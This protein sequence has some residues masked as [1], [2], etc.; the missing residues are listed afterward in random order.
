MTIKFVQ[1]LSELLGNDTLARIY[2]IEFSSYASEII[3]VD[4][5]VSGLWVSVST[6]TLC[7]TEF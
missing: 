5:D 2:F 6:W 7:L 1:G 4:D 3:G